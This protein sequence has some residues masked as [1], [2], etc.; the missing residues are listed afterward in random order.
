MNRGK[1]LLI[2]LIIM[3][4]ISFST[5]AQKRK[6]GLP[7][8]EENTKSIVDAD[9]IY[10]Y[11]WDMANMKLSDGTWVDKAEE[12][13]PRI[14]S[15]IGMLSDR[16]SPAY[17]SKAL[18]K[19]VQA[20]LDVIQKLYIESDYKDFVTFNPYKLSKESLIE[21]VEGYELSDNSGVGL[22]IIAEN[23]NKNERYTTAFVTFFD[24]ETRQLLWVTK[25]KG[26][27]GS[28]WGFSKYWYEGY[29]E[30]FYYFLKKYYPP[31]S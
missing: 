14:S 12:L 1:L 13:R 30:C 3:L 20:D 9:T 11:G 18:Q 17:V 6:S 29:L 22:V 27:P 24:L 28:K 25:M 19:E 2:T 21:I 23:M 15:I 5:K 26:L 31:H 10:Y 8:V 4:S 16:F 7:I